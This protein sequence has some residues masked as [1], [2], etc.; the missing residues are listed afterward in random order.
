MVNTSR[1]MRCYLKG[2]TNSPLAQFSLSSENENDTGDGGG[3]PVFTFW[4]ISL[5]GM[6]TAYANEELLLSSI[7]ILDCPSEQ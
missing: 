5:F 4:P 3:A 7:L 2:T 1:S 6:S